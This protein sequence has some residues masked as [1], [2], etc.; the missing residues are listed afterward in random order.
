MCARGHSEPAVGSRKG[1][2]IWINKQDSSKI[3]PATTGFIIEENVAMRVDSLAKFVTCFKYSQILLDGDVDN[4][5]FLTVT[6]MKR[7]MDHVTFN[8]CMNSA[9]VFDSSTWQVLP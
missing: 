8:S 4:L 1:R 9:K 3:L 5:L 6:S 2:V 7:M